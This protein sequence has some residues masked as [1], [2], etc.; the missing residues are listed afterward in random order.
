MIH[1]S[2]ELLLNILIEQR[3]LLDIKKSISINSIENN[4]IWIRV[5]F[6]ISNKKLQFNYQVQET[7]GDIRSGVAEI[8]GSTW[9]CIIINNWGRKY[10]NYGQRMSDVSSIDEG[11]LATEVMMPMNLVQLQ[12]M[13]QGTIST[14]TF[15]SNI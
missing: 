14:Y 9:S 13:I 2:F 7:D 12:N 3:K 1:Y 15:T 8:G 11:Y 4:S 10:Y 6:N 5:N